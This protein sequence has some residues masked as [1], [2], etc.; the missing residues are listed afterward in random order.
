VVRKFLS[1]ESYWAKGRSEEVIRC[2]IENS[3]PFSVFEGERQIAFARVVT[4]YATFAWIAD[5][6]V[7][8]SHRGRGIGKLL[9]QEITVHPKL[10]SLT[11]WALATKDAQNL[12][13]KFGFTELKC[14][15]RWMERT[16]RDYYR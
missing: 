6:F 15:E 2:S 4:D 14:P 1:E 12:Y 13:S 7:S 10:Q 5:V 3:L 16:A 11:R 8:E 9:M